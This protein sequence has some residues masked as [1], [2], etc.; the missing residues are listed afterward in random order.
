MRRPIHLFVKGPDS[1]I[2]DP[3]SFI[4][5]PDSFIGD[6][7]SF[8][9]DPDSARRC[10]DS[11]RRYPDSARRNP[12]LLAE[13]QI[14]SPKSRSAR[15]NPDLLAEIRIRSPKDPDPLAERS[16]PPVGG[17]TFQ[18]RIP[19]SKRVFQS[20]KMNIPIPKRVTEKDDRDY[21]VTRTVEWQ[22][23]SCF[24][25]LC[26]SSDSWQFRLYNLVFTVSSLQ[27]RLYNL[28]FTI[29]SLQCYLYFFR[30]WSVVR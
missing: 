29:S 19:V 7:D 15:R 3:D 28:V 18:S 17:W 30:Q 22:R 24:R 12:D 14:C 25:A 6:P 1:F 11:A 9:R 27:S 8:I 23:G 5:D 13:I 16:W 20:P 21:R 26:F 10:P 4:K 2:K